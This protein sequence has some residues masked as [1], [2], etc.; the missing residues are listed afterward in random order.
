MFYHDEP[1]PPPEPPP[2]KPPPEN[3]PELLELSGVETIALS[4]ESNDLSSV[5]MNWRIPGLSKSSPSN[6]P[7]GHPGAS[8]GRSSRKNRSTG[9]KH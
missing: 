1:P 9:T 6:A 5:L 4:N 3:P 8:T 7:T 2:E